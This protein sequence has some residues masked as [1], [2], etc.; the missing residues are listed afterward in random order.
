MLRN[1]I[2]GL[3]FIVI[4]SAAL[5]FLSGPIDAAD[6]EIHHNPKEYVLDKFQSH[7]LL[8]LGTRHKREPI[9]QFISDLLPSLHG[10]GVTHVGLEICSNQR[11]R[12][13]SHLN[14]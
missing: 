7:D 6:Y 12:P 3:I 13:G 14:Y 2:H 4:V 1:K 5:P 8:M 9:L 10:A 11:E